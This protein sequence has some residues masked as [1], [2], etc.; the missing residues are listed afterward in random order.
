MKNLFLNFFVLASVATTLHSCTGRDNVEQAGL[1]EIHIDYSK[2]QKSIKFSDIISSDI[3]VVPLSNVDANGDYFYMA[4]I[5]V[6]EKKGEQ[7]FLFNIFNDGQL[8][9]FD[10]QGGFVRNI[11][12]RGNGLGQY[13]QAMD[14]SLDE[15]G[16][17]VLD[18]GKIHRFGHDGSYISSKKLQGF[19]AS[20]FRKLDNGY[21]FVSSGRN[22]HNLLLADSSLNLVSSHFPYLT[23]PINALLLNP[24]FTNANNQTIYRRSLNDTL[25]TL[26]NLDCPEPYIKIQYG[27]KAPKLYDWVSESEE[28]IAAE[29][30]KASNTLYFFESEKYRFLSFF[31]D[32]EKWN[33]IY[34]NQSGKSI[35][36]KSSDLIDDVTLDPFSYIV[37]VSGETFYFLSKPERVLQNFSENLL[38]KHDVGYIQKLRSVS[39]NLDIEGNPVLFGVKFDF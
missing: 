1:Q 21:A 4:S 9:V 14:F 25:F 22:E 31:L 33:N 2:A 30:S 28:R 7:F 6:F 36:F 35:I 15:E 27:A 12:S 23:R 29:I 20:R 39:E 17:E 24:L 16:V 26:S 3:E 32:G 13:L 10:A 5:D 11:G 18:V 19:M 38:Q 34:S 37:G 8:R